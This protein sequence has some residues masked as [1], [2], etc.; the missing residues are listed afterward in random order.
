[1]FF[2][3]LQVCERLVTFIRMVDY[4][5]RLVLH[6]ITINSLTAINKSL[7][8]RA[9]TRPSPE[10]KK[11]AETGE[12]D[13]PSSKEAEAN[14]AEQEIPVFTCLV[15]VN[16]ERE[17]S[18]TPDLAAF[19]NGF[20]NFLT[21]LN[22][23]IQSIPLLYDDESFHPF[24]QPILYGKIEAHQFSFETSFLSGHEGTHY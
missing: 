4:S 10:E 24:A 3:F 2:F 7:V 18:I 13:K 1:M 8:S 11:R 20:T 6:E 16:N 23:V 21:K 15:S 17:I 12:K 19:D 14:E 22:D 5:I 9:K